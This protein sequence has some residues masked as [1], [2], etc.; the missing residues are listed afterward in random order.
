MNPGT[1]GGHIGA[2]GQ[3]VHRH[4]AWGWQACDACQGAKLQVLQS[5][6]FTGECG[7]GVAG[8][9]GL[10]AQ[11]LGVLAYFGQAGFA[12]LQLGRAVQARPQAGL[13]QCHDVLTL[14][15]IA[16]RQV[17]QGLQAQE[18]E[19]AAGD[20]AGQQQ[21]SG[22]AV[23]LGRAH[24][25]QCGVQRRAVFAKEVKLV[26]GAHLCIGHFNHIAGQRRRI[27]AIGGDALAHGFSRSRDVGQVCASHHASQ[28]LCTRH[29]G[30]RKPQT[31]LLVQ[32]FLHQCVQLCITKTAP[33]RNTL[34][35]YLCCG[36]VACSSAVQTQC[37][38]F[39]HVRLRANATKVGATA[40]SER[41]CG[42]GGRA[43]PRHLRS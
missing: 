16:L 1:G 39:G 20:L 7:Q 19:I 13:H 24:L 32:C 36:G 17:L 31:G 6:G 3:Q 5:Q 35:C 43:L 21:F 38:G 8:Q 2:V 22:L 18:R 9:R 27:N 11:G 30:L 37:L 42:Q 25:A 15:Q 12:A 14:G 41:Q 26:A 10:L 28:R 34:G 33:P 40:Q 4:G 23:G 29:T